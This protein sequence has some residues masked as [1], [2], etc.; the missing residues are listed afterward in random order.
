MSAADYA[1]LGL[2]PTAS[3]EDVKKTFKKLALK[4]HPDKG[5]SH[6][7]WVKLQTAYEHIVNPTPS[8]ANQMNEMVTPPVVHTIKIS[9]EQLYTG[10]TRKLKINRDI[11]C[12][13]CNGACIC[14]SCGGKGIV[15][16]IIQMGPMVQQ[17][18][19][20][21]QDCNGGRK[22]RGSCQACKNTGLIK[23]GK[24]IEVN[25]KPG[26]LN[27]IFRFPNQGDYQFN[28]KPGDVIIKIEPLPHN[29]YTPLNGGHLLI[30][31]SI[32]LQDALM[33]H[34]LTFTHLDQRKINIIV[35]YIKPGAPYIL[36]GEGLLKGK[37]HLVIEFEIIFPETPD[38]KWCDIYGPRIKDTIDESY[39][40]M[41][42]LTKPL[43]GNENEDDDE[44]ENMNGHIPHPGQCRQM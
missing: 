33:G 24:I 11:L 25:I 22:S 28:G 40:E 27:Q 43:E 10:Y 5:G 8:S 12:S 42:R 37:S 7:E 3:I 20:P 1:I 16:R 38:M 6:D 39:M 14:K 41:T 32:K 23:E 31:K 34:T 30:K 35:D 26:Q 17:M 21:C 13:S 36:H 2:T 4:H 29:S 9:L 18:Q 19:T 15:V 44:N